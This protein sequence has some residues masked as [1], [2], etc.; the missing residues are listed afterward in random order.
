MELE[1]SLRPK[2]RPKK[3]KSLL[4]KLSDFGSGFAKDLAAIPSSI[5]SDIGMGLG[6]IDKDVSHGP[7]SGYDERTAITRARNLEA[8][9]LKTMPTSRDD[10]KQRTVADVLAPSDDPMSDALQKAADDLAKE[11]AK[12]TEDTIQQTVA[13][14]FRSGARGRR[15]LLRSTSG[16]GMGFYNRFAT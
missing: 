4:N 11:K 13:K 3:K 6:L 14:R 12:A 8:A 15:S 10:D 2:L 9:R 5:A 1:T 16:G 7:H